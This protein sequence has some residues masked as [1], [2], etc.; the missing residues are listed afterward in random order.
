MK[1]PFHREEGGQE[2]MNEQR[3]QRDMAGTLFKQRER[4]SEK[5]PDFT[6]RITIGGR[7]YRLSGWKR[8]TKDGG[9]TY[10]SLAVRELDARPT[11]AREEDF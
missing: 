9:E 3:E 2:T 6:G 4:R 8:T 10:L 11:T 5:S 1:P 7:T